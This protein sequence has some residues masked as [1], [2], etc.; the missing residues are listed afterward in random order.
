MDDQDGDKRRL[1]LLG[2]MLQNDFRPEDLVGLTAEPDDFVARGR[3]E[4]E[5]LVSTMHAV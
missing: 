4:S 5:L 3:L 1:M 2:R